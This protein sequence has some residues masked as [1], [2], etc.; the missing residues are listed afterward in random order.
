MTMLSVLAFFCGVAHPYVINVVGEVFLTELLLIPLSIG[1]FLFG[2]NQSI[3]KQRILI[4]IVFSALISLAGYMLT[5]LYLGTPPERYLRGWGRVVFMVSDFVALS[6]LAVNH[7][8]NIW[9]FVFGIGTGKLVALML[10]A[11]PLSGW[12]L[13]YGEGVILVAACL[14][15]VISIRINSMAFALVGLLSVALDSRIQGLICLL[16]AILLWVRAKQPSQPLRGLSQYWRVILVGI[17]AVAV[18]GGIYIQTQQ[19]FSDRRE[20]SAIGRMVMIRVSL[21]AIAESPLIG[22]GS[23]AE[24]ERFAKMTKMEIAKGEGKSQ[25]VTVNSGFFGAH[26]QILQAWVEGGILAITFFV[27]FGYQSFRAL[28]YVVLRRPVDSHTSIFMYILTF[29][30]WH[31]FMSP[32]AGIHRIYIG[33]SVA[34]ICALALEIHAKKLELR[35]SVIDPGLNQLAR[36]KIT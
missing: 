6:L 9:W 20:Q 24:D 17:I 33:M 21:S 18:F 28:K 16:V 7:K 32:F 22:Y 4:L 1:V 5:D 36:G 12:K 35:N 23:W 11:I 31:L 26:S 13:G 15:S 19:E 14:T 3:L 8:R 29:G 25:L 34:I 27:V 10:G 30:L 2:K